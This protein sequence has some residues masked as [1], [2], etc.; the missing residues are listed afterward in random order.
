[1]RINVQKKI[2]VKVNSRGKLYVEKVAILGDLNQNLN[3]GT[4]LD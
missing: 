1:M 2:N 4:F 3:K